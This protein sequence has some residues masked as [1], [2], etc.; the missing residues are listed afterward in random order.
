MRIRVF[1]GIVSI[2]IPFSYPITGFVI[3]AVS[4]AILGEDY[5]FPNITLSSP[6]F[7]FA[8]LPGATRS[9]DITIIDNNVAKYHDFDYIGHLI[10]FDI[11]VYVSEGRDFC[12]RHRVH[13]EDDD[14]MFFKLSY[15]S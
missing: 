5:E 11:W 10:T 3:Y 7:D 8:I 2:A 14:G 1:L 13:I 15:N 12:G 9:F 4:D 6:Y